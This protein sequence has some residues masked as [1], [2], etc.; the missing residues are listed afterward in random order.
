MDVGSVMFSNGSFQATSVNPCCP[1]LEPN[2]ALSPIFV[3]IHG[4][5]QEGGC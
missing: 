3:W 5:A 2:D 1:Q 4:G